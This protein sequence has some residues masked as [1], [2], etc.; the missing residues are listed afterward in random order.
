M[1]DWFEVLK[2]LFILEGSVFPLQRFFQ[3]GIVG[4]AP[5]RPSSYPAQLNP[6]TLAQFIFEA[7]QYHG[8]RV[9]GNAERTDSFSQ[10]AGWPAAD[11]GFTSSNT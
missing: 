11:S 4:Q 2:A 6:P 5:L 9:H 1:R 10:G 3:I 7:F 8:F